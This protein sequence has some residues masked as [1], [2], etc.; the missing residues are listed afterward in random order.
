MTFEEWW[1]NRFGYEYDP[2]DTLFSNKDVRTAWIDGHIEGEETATRAEKE[3]IVG[4]MEDELDALKPSGDIADALH[5]I[6]HR[7]ATAILEEA[8]DV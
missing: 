4:I 8:N 6:L 2:D 5:F 1:L 7:L 3:R